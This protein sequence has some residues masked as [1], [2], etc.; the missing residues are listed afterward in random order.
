MFRKR[1]KSDSRPEQTSPETKENRDETKK[2]R[3]DF[4]PT[5]ELFKNFR[6]IKSLKIKS[7]SNLS[8]IGE[9]KSCEFLDDTS[10]KACAARCSKS[11]ECLE[12]SPSY[13]YLDDSDAPELS[14]EL[15][16]DV[17]A[18]LSLPQDI[19][20]LILRGR[21]RIDSIA[22]KQVA[23]NAYMPMSPIVA[24]PTP[25]EQHYIVMSPRANIA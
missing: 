9:T 16:D 19:L 21:E 11:V 5:K 23:E 4:A 8:K 6:K 2:K 7:G 24:P 14:L 18:S 20:A 3:F 1:L 25:I 10:S 15:D 13:D 22:T 17:A 12:G